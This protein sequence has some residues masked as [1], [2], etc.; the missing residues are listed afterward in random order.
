[1][2]SLTEQMMLFDPESYRGS[3]ATG[4]PENVERRARLAAKTRLFEMPRYDRTIGESDE[5]RG[6]EFSATSNEWHQYCGGVGVMLSA[7]KI[8]LTGAR[9]YMCDTLGV[10][11]FR[12]TE[13]LQAIAADVAEEYR[14]FYPVRSVNVIMEP[15]W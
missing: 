5:D 7:E 13:D 1:M 4:L 6:V 11:Y 12:F 2:A 9:T 10:D 8:A 3:M 15:G 14:S